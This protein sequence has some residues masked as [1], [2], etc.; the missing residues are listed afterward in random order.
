MKTRSITEVLDAEYAEYGM[1]TIEQRAIPSAVDG[2]KPTQRKAAFAATD[3]W[4]RGDEKPLKVFQLTGRMAAQCAYHH[5]DASAN[6]TIVGMAQSFKNSLPIFE[7]IGQFG[8]LRA[9]EAGAPRYIST[10]LTPNFRLLYKDDRLLERKIEDGQQIEP[11]FFL[12]VVPAVLLNGSSGIAVG[13][14]TNILNREPRALTQACIAALE[15]KRM[16]EPLPWWRDF[17]GTVEQIAPGQ[18]SMRG[19]WEREDSTTVRVTELPPSMTF[20]RY[21]AHL[22]SLVE[23]GHIARYEDSSS[24]RPDY[25]VK[26]TRA[27]L[28]SLIDSG[29]MDKL[30][31]L[32]EQETENITCLDENGRLREFDSAGELIKWFVGFRL[33]YYGKRRDLMLGDL[34]ER[35]LLLSN[36]ARFITMILEGKLVVQKRQRKDLETELQFLKFDQKDGGYSYL[37]SM[38]IHSLTRETYDQLMAELAEVQAEEKRVRALKPVEMYREDLDLLLKSLK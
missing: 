1:Y 36:R 24:A 2:F 7:E 17:S 26:F 15:G 37:L 21:E 14:A 11:R 23:K 27:G 5:G 18:F 8:S 38:P 20:A 25:T 9:P 3:V 29:G 6:S 31:R 16:K 35:S 34:T 28:Q 33:G 19:T 4:K 22:D 30:L 12:P 32:T 13:F 10:R